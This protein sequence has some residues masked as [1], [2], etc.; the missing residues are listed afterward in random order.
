MSEPLNI[1]LVEDN[2][3]DV[4][5]MRRG[6]DRID[7]ASFLVRAKDGL[8]ALDILN[9]APDDAVLPHPFVI[10]LDINMPRMNGHEFLETLR[11]DPEIAASRVIVFTTSSNPRDVSRAYRHNAVGY[12][13]KPDTLADLQKS[14]KAIWEFWDQ[15]T[16]P[17]GKPVH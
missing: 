5:L 2:D 14:L 16:H 8:E 1:L 6:L 9:A 11:E 12:M 7:A 3:V 13:V 15:C 17:P 10:L 4:D